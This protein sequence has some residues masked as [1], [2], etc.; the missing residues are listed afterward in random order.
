MAKRNNGSFRS[1]RVGSITLACV[2]TRFD[3]QRSP[4][5]YDR[6]FNGM[7]LSFILQATS[8]LQ[9]FANIWLYGHKDISTLLRRVLNV[10]SFDE[11]NWTM[12][13]LRA[14]SSDQ[15][16]SPRTAD[17]TYLR[18]TLTV[19]L[20]GAAC[21]ASVSAWPSRAN[22]AGASRLAGR[23]IWGTCTTIFRL[24]LRCG[25]RLGHALHPNRSS[26]PTTGLT[27]CL[28]PTP[29]FALSKGILQMNWMPCSVRCPK[30]RSIAS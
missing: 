13:A 9:S 7:A 2:D 24:L 5:E 26:S 21:Q 22:V 23:T 15:A 3:K 4:A 12:R 27:R 28:S 11:G 17:D 19:S 6:L 10:C 8:C 14:Q 16:I 1:G 30:L 25:R 29:N 20:Q 18:Y